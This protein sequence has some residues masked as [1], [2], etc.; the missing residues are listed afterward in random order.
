[1][2]IYKENE[3]QSQISFSNKWKKLKIELKVEILVKFLQK[4]LWETIGIIST[5]N[6]KQKLNRSILFC[7]QNGDKL[8]RIFGVLIDVNGLT[9]S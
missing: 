3:I 5:D 8:L 1:M 2:Q 4:I 6:K 7:F 9:T